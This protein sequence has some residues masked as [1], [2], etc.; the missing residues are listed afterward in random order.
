MSTVSRGS[1]VFSGTSA[2]GPHVAGAAALVWSARPTWSNLEVRRFLEHGAV[3]MG[4]PGCDMDYGCG[5]LYMGVPLAP[6]AQCVPDVAPLTDD[7][8]AEGGSGSTTVAVASGCPWFADSPT[9]WIHVTEGGAGDGNG[10]VVFAVDPS[11]VCVTREGVVFAAGA[12]I[13]VTQDGHDPR[14]CPR[15][16]SG[17]VVSGASD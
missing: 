14:T 12:R 3:D 8:P 13:T 5:R 4:A 7:I 1:Q 6:A 17:R 11:P 2:A 15:H 16:A 9:K 10:T